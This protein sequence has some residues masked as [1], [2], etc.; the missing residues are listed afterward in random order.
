MTN[1][2]RIIPWLCLFLAILGCSEPFEAA[3]DPGTGGSAPN[4]STLASTAASTGGQASVVAET[5]GSAPQAETGGANQVIAE[6]GG[7]EPVSTGGQA[8]VPATGGSA[9]MATG[10]Q[11]ATSTGGSAPMAT[12]ASGG[13]S[14]QTTNPINCG[15]AMG[16]TSSQVCCM[17][18]QNG[19][20][21]PTCNASSTVCHQ[22]DNGT[23]TWVGSKTW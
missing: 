9:P 22:G 19:V 8:A 7:Q 18:V 17:R 20:T 3:A 1:L 11:A 4:L 23:V 15:P 12:T 21:Y 6:T 13:Y 14:I 5:G 16:C 2:M 10:G